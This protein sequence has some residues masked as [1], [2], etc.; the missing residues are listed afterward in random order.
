MSDPD[1]AALCAQANL[2]G[3]LPIPHTLVA[4]PRR[5]AAAW[6]ARW[7]TTRLGGGQ[8]P[9]IKF[10]RP[11]LATGSVK[12]AS[13]VGDTEILVADGMGLADTAAL[14]AHETR[15]AAGYSDEIGAAALQRECQRAWAAD[16]IERREQIFTALRQLA[17]RTCPDG[18]WAGAKGMKM[19]QAWFGGCPEPVAYESIKLVTDELDWLLTASDPLDHISHLRIKTP[20]PPRPQFAWDH[21]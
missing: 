8:V 3:E 13:R 2:A 6:G 1:Y 21:S 10:F 7:A 19:V 18:V 12:G 15:H 4:L 20:T 9:Q 14:A 11:T 17:D 16:R 5:S